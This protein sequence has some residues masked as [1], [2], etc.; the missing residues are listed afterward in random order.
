MALADHVPARPPSALPPPPALP[1]HVATHAPRQ[2]GN[3]A[4]NTIAMYK[5]GTVFRPQPFYK[6]FIYIEQRTLCRKKEGTKQ[7]SHCQHP[8]HRN[9]TEARVQLGDSAKQRQVL[10][11]P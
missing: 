6:P 3:A 5:P 1:P 8:S 4:G 7:A 11:W 2:R 9:A 10:G